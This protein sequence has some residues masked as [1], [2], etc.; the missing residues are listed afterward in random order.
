MRVGDA[1]VLCARY[2][3]RGSYG[4]Q[5]PFATPSA[6]GH[7]ERMGSLRFVIALH[8][9]GNAACLERGTQAQIGLRY[10][11]RAWRGLGVAR[12]APA[13]VRL[14]CAARSEQRGRQQRA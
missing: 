3:L 4:L 12:R 10:R 7:F 1:R 8:E 2:G 9:H 14:R 13:L 11:E 5:R 6:D